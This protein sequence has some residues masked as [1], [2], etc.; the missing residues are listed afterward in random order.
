MTPRPSVRTYTHTHTHTHTLTHQRDGAGS[1]T[2]LTDNA[3]WHSSTLCPYKLFLQTALAIGHVR[4][5]VSTVNYLTLTSLG[6]KVE[7]KGQYKSLCAARV[8]TA[9]SYEYLLTAV[10]V[11]FHVDGNS[12]ELARRGVRSG[13][14]EVGVQRVWAW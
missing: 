10:V 13:A 6:L 7:V 2:N 1:R 5:S 3:F 11:G 12:C 4:P 14:A 9:T 8:S